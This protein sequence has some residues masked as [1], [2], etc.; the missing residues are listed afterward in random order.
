M[1]VC[2]DR[3]DAG[4]FH[5]LV[6]VAAA[7]E[8][9][10]CRNWMVG[11]PQEEDLTAAPMEASSLRILCLEEGKN[12]GYGALALLVSRLDRCSDSGSCALSPC[13]A[14]R[15]DLPANPSK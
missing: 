13:I 11:T 8:W 4:P 7:A 12:T 15:R 2:K 5:L 3:L 1:S 14:V 10:G 9:K 6:V